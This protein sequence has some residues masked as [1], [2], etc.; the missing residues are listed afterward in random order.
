MNYKTLKDAGDIKGK[1]VLLRLDFNVPIQDGKITDDYRIKKSLPTLRYL[2]EHGAKIIIIAHIEGE[3][4]T[5]KPVFEYLKT[6]EPVTFCEDCVENGHACIENMQEGEMLLCENLRLYDGE[7]RNDEEFSKK[8]ASLADIYVND[9]FS[10]SH[11]KHASVGGVT[12]FLPSYAGLQLEAEIENLSKVFNPQKPFIFILGGAKFDTKMPLVEKFLPLADTIFIGGAMANDFFKAQ[13][14]E[15]GK[16]KIADEPLDLSALLTHPKILLPID[17]V[18]DGPRGKKTKKP[19]EVEADESIRDVGEETV[20]LLAQRIKDA[21]TILWNGPL[22]Y[23][24]GGFKQPTLDIAEVIAHSSAHSVLG[25]GDTLA[26]I[27]ELGLE[28]KYSFV[29]TG[30]GAMLDFLSQGSLPGID[31]LK[32]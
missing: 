31:A 29:S 1:K 24:E 14:L 11:R 8:L 32:K 30:G 19:S 16:S 20:A 4:D 2:K 7:K 26:A 17:I 28:D 9:G 22:G 5:L 27:A 23:F 3:S 18:A 12:K 10:V 15:V 21:K 6:S 25:G 13:G